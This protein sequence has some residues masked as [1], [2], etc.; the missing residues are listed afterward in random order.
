MSRYRE[1]CDSLRVGQAKAQEEQLEHE[2]EERTLPQAVAEVVRRM[3]AYFQC[4][5]GRV[6]YID[7][8]SGIATGMLRTGTPL[9]P[10]NPEKGRHCL[11]FQIDVA[12]TLEED[13]HPVWAHL[14]C[15]QLR[16]GGLELHLGPAIFQLPDEEKVLFDELAAAINRRLREG[17]RPGP[18]KVGW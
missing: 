18:T 14:E 17:H 6:R 16:H 2:D 4:P 9:L 8:R 1:F 5:E 13:R 3:C 11:D 12:D 10:F 7:P 15:A